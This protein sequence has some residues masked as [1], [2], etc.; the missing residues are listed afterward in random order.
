[1]LSFYRDGIP[2]K[3]SPRRRHHHYIYMYKYFLVILFLFFI[4][5]NKKLLLYYH[6]SYVRAKYFKIAS[7]YGIGGSFVS[8]FRCIW[9]G[10]V[11]V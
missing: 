6:L 1:M 5:K 11:R 4:Y 3:S 2:A 7:K 10:Q 9:L 8:Y